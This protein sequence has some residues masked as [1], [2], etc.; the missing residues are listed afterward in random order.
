MI[1]MRKFTPF[2]EKNIEFL[3]NKNIRFTQ[4]QAT[5]TGLN[6]SILDATAPMRTF[7]LEMGIHD[8][9]EQ[10]KGTL[11]KKI[12]DCT[13]LTDTSSEKKNASF[14]RP[15]TKDGDPRVWFYGL[16]KYSD[17]NDI[18]VIFYFD[19]ML[20]VANLSKIDFESC[21]RRYTL[22]P[23][24]EVIEAYYLSTISVSKE[25]LSKFMSVS[26]QWFEAEVQADT[27]IG[28][29]V[30]SFLGL[31]MNS[32]KT[33]DYKGIELKSH[34]DKRSS[35]KNVLFTQTPNWD[36]SVMKSGK[37]IVENYG[38]YKTPDS[39]KKTLEVTVQANVPNNQSLVLNVNLIQAL[40]EMQSSSTSGIEDVAVWQLKS[41]HERL[42]TKHKETFWIEVENV[43]NNGKEYFRYKQ[44]EHTMNPNVG[45]FDNLVEQQLITLDLML[46]RP[47]GH[48]DTYSFKIKKAGMPLLFPTSKI[49]D[50]LPSVIDESFN[51]AA[52]P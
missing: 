32:D 33:P 29:A 44:I 36:L 9:S 15:E 51:I 11:H 4:V 25:L 2:E 47:S 5:E 26:G 43:K 24:K 39:S 41:L 6:K 34:R 46:C 12:I 16:K 22:T 52:E 23:L 37:Q 14:Y 35:T 45:Q 20:Y 48:G 38:Y 42:L 3:V 7:F 17:A 1:H 30:E 50:I 13:I 8:Y 27:G 49:Y 21:C 19:K 28:R 40:L 31:K 10:E 18:H